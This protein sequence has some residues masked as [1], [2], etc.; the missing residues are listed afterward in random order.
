MPPGSVV[1]MLV[2]VGG[3]VMFA[4]N[5]FESGV[6][7]RGVLTALLSNVILGLRNVGIK[8]DQ[9]TGK[10]M[11]VSSERRLLAYGL[12][13]ASLLTAA[14]LLE[15]HAS[16]L[17]A[18]SSYFLSLAF[19]SSLCHVTYSYVSTNVVLRYMTVVSHSIANVVKRVLVVLMLYPEENRGV[20]F[21]DG[22]V[23]D[24]I[25]LVIR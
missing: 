16:I 14:Y 19:A 25:G 15:T 20:A 5:P 9:T 1:S 23:C 24:I 8:L 6:V 3:A 2:I 4:G 11:R 21:I 12:A 10:H 22:V 7:V 13:V 17:P 18:G